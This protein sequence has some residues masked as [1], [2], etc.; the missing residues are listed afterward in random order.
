MTDMEAIVQDVIFLD[1]LKKYFKM[2]R[3]GSKGTSQ[4]DPIR[5]VPIY[6]TNDPRA[7]SYQMRKNHLSILVILEPNI[8]S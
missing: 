2:E 7:T 3:R 6:T 1:K 5:R 4:W 8:A